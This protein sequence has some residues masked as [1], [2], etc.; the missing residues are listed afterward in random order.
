M[1]ERMNNFKEKNHSYRYITP[2]NIL[3]RQKNDSFY[4]EEN[5]DSYNKKLSN[6]SIQR[7][8]YNIYNEENSS[9]KRITPKKQILFKKKIIFSDKDKIRN[10]YASSLINN[11][12]EYIRRKIE[13][14][15]IRERERK[16]YEWFYINNID[17]SKRDFY[18]AF[19][20]LIQSVFRGYFTRK[21]IKKLNAIFVLVFKFN[22]KYYFK[23]FFDFLKY[24][25]NLI[26]EPYEN[27]N[28]F[29]DIRQLIKQNNELQ[30]KLEII[31]TENNKLRKEKEKYKENEKKYNDA[32]GKIEKFFKT[33]GE[34]KKSKEEINILKNKEG[35]KK[36]HIFDLG[37]LK[38]GKNIQFSLNLKNNRDILIKNFKDNNKI[39]NF[40]ITILPIPKN[41]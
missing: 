32:I 26:V 7:I 6:Y 35:N 12:I 11:D 19:S 15:E 36:V 10:I 16:I 27:K 37:K 30:Q 34:N 24:K 31:L 18:E 17:I 20:T 39:E 4:L 41:Y 21:R 38:Q 3:Y 25:S 9:S 40:H 33:S 5:A 14:D 22:L 2:R 28:L 1:F 13:S 23:Y 29:E 8:N